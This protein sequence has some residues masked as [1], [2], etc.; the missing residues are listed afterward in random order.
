MSS[1]NYMDKIP[2]NVNLGTDRQ[3]QRALEHWQPRFLNWWDASGPSDFK[4]SDVYL[5]TAVGVDAQGWAS[6]GKVKMPDYRWGIFMNDSEP[7]RR[8]GFGDFAGQPVWQ[9]VPGEFR[10]TLR[11]FIVTQGD[12]EPASVEQQRLL[13]HIAPSLYDLRNLFQ[14]NVEEGRHLWAMV[15]LLHAYFGRDG[16]EEAEAL[17]ER[18]SGDP[19]NSR[20]LGTFNEPIE[21][22]LSLFMFT[23]FTDRDGKYQ[24]K[25]FAESAFD[26]LARTCRFMLTEEAHH[27]FVGDTGI[28]RV[29]KRTLELMT[30]LKTDDPIAIRKAGGIDLPLLQ[31][32]INYWFTSS[33]DLFGGED[34]SNAATAFANGLKGRPDE[35]SY[36]NHDERESVF[37]LATPDDKW[38]MTSEGILVKNIATRNAMNE[39]VRMAYV[40]DCE[41][42]FKR[43]NRAIERGGF[44]FQLALPST[45]FRRTI[46]VWAGIPTTPEGKRI[47]QEAFDSNINSWV[48]TK[49]DKEFVKS[50]MVLVTE[51]GKMAGW[52]AAPD[53]GINN[54]DVAHDY[55]NL[56][57]Q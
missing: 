11:R 29:I 5:R 12:T 35:A 10:S 27:M 1:I 37:E 39:T 55:V 7:N 28:G 56:Q 52:L 24:L 32:Y 51:P 42:G 46:G 34:S 40:K 47:S 9:Q 6:Y 19:D 20:I 3:L 44:N 23:Y 25:S 57:V 48:P 4:G 31:K 53:R 54:L 33:L 49:E 15:Y 30:E 21:D 26:P 18:T 41:L 45:R 43:W 50:L 38:D 2:N 22:W 13:G 8:I 17:L 36:A 16:R 14:I